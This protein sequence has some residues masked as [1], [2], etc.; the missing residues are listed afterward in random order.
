MDLPF[1]EEL[2]G[3]PYLGRFYAEVLSGHNTLVYIGLSMVPLTWWLLFRTR[4][5]LRLR[6]VGE[7][8]GAVDTAGIAVNVACASEP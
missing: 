8:P 5:G 6:A 7:N 3:I 4:F 1:A 2:S